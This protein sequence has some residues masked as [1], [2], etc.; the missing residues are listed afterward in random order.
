MGLT[1]DRDANSFA[2]LK[3]VTTPT[4][5]ALRDDRYLAGLDLTNEGRGFKLAYVVRAV[6][7]GSYVQPGTQVEDMYA[8]AY[9][10]R[11]AAS[12]LDVKLARKP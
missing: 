3:D 1:G 9:H 4:F 2:W 12:A 6:T 5:T 8:P 7:P 11:G 10:A